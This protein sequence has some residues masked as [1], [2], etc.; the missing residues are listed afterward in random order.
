M[1]ERVPAD[2]RAE[3]RC[4]PCR[5]DLPL[6]DTPTPIGPFPILQWAGEHPIGITMERCFGF[7]TPEEFRERRV[8]GKTGPRI[9]GLNFVDDS[10]HNSPSNQKAEGFPLEV[11]PLQS[12]QLTAPKTC[13]HVQDDHCAIRFFVNLCQQAMTFVQC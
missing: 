1:P 6:L 9:L 2:A 13:S 3:P 5:F 4:P 10:S 11:L 8:K 7:P 12:Q